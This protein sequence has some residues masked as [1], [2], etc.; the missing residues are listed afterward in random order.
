MDSAAPGESFSSPNAKVFLQS[1]QAGADG[2]RVRVTLSDGSS[3]FLLPEQVME[4][5]LAE[6][7]EL[8]DSLFLLLCAEDEYLRCRDKALDL[9]NRRDHA[10]SE[11]RRKLLQRTFSSPAIDR[12]ITRLRE[13]KLID[14]YRFA[15][16]WL[17]SRINR[18]AEGR[19]K[20]TALL[21]QKGIS[22]G[23]LEKL[24]ELH[25]GEEEENRA[26]RRAFEKLSGAKK[27]DC[28]SAA[29]ALL[30]KGFPKSRV[31]R[32]LEDFFS[33]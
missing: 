20:L 3:F 28:R 29:A 31:F 1:L 21:H 13:L 14:D 12:T 15:E 2:K 6:G 33:E 4:L 23:V 25:F 11:L 18:K 10:E 19:A 5:R 16:A 26:L 32:L 27:G 9:L 24:L 7:M 22:R 17:L 30:R 8:D